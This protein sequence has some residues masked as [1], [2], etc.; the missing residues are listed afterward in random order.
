[1]PDNSYKYYCNKEC[2]YF[3]CHDSK[4]DYFN[5]MFCFCPLYLLGREC[6]GNFTYLENGIKDCSACRLPHSPGGYEYIVEKLK[7]QA[8]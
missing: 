8:P 1:M 4:G 6:G 5:C 7:K 3:P 2:K